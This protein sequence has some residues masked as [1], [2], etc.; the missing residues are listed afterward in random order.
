M[1]GNSAQ[2]NIQA[3]PVKAPTIRISDEIYHTLMKTHYNI[4]TTE[5]HF[6]WARTSLYILLFCLIIETVLI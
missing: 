6:I 5:I 1:Y 4:K 3:M 2:K